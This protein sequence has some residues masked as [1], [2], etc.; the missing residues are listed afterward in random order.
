MVIN[1][2]SDNYSE[3]IVK[4]NGT[5]LENVKEFSYLGSKIEFNEAQLGP[6][7]ISNRTSSANSAFQ[8]HKS[9][10]RNFHINLHTRIQFFNS[11]IRP[12]LT[13]G[14]EIWSLTN[15]IF[16]KFDTCQRTFLRKRVYGR[17]HRKEDSFHY[18]INN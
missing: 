18:K 1:N 4:L 7:E 10:L 13:Y 16:A 17:F 2:S 5:N 14:C 9:L 3:H 8:Q 12:R 15:K 11:L 6:S